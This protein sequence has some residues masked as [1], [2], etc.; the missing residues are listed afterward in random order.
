M[1]DTIETELQRQ[2]NLHRKSYTQ[3]QAFFASRG[4]KV[5]AFDEDETRR[6]IERE[7]SFCCYGVRHRTFDYPNAFGAPKPIGVQQ[8]YRLPIIEGTKI[9]GAEFKIQDSDPLPGQLLCQ[10]ASVQA[11]PEVPYPWVNRA[12]ALTLGF[13]EDSIHSQDW[14]IADMGCLYFSIDNGTVYV[15]GESY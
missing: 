14:M 6:S 2:L 10:L 11:A 1:A 5:R 13:G 15:N 9:G 7:L 8:G 3:S 4:E 12:K